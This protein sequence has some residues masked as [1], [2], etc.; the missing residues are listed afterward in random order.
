MC[1]IQSD[2]QKGRGNFW[3]AVRNKQ[4]IGAIAL[5]DIGNAQAALR[6]MFVNKT[7]RGGRYRVAP[8][9]LE[10]LFTSARFNGMKEIF[11]GTTPQF[12]AAHRFYEKNG[13]IEIKKDALPKNFPIMEVNTKFYKFELEAISKKPK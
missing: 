11:L 8:M 5:L 6:K 1:H 10:E 7:Y 12:L 13:F 2:Y 9:L 3:I 4:V